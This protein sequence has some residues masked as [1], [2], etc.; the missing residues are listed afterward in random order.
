[1]ATFVR[2]ETAVRVQPAVAA[3]PTEGPWRL[4]S[5]D[6][7]RGLVMVV[8][9]LDHTR[10]YFS[11]AQF[12]PVDLSQTTPAYFL[13][14]WITHFCAPTFVFLAGTGAYLAGMRGKS[15]PQLSWF[16]L[17]RGLWLVVLEFTLVQWGWNFNFD[18]HFV[19]GAVIWAIGCSMMLLAA[20]VWLPTSAIGVFGVAVIAFHNLLDNVQPDDLGR[21]GWLWQ[22]L[23]SGGVFEPWQGFRFAAAYPLLPWMG[24]M[25]VGYAFGS[26]YRLDTSKRWK[27]LLG[28]G[29]MLTLAFIILRRSNLYGDPRPWEEQKNELFTLF[30][31]LNCW[32]YPPSLLFL[33]MTLGPAIFALGL[34]GFG[35]GP[36]GQPLVVFG[37][38]PLFFYLLHIPLIHL[39][40]AV[41][42]TMRFGGSPLWSDFWGIPPEQFRIESRFQLPV[43]Y[44]FWVMVVSILY[45]ACWWWA[46]VKQRRRYWWLSYL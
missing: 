33:L 6:L 46:R 30:S 35:L 5:V 17:S 37:R 15:K 40:A 28:L 45:P 21:L 39:L 29:A 4:D 27:L 41:C 12:D 3:R 43:V 24:V 44:L 10:A 32:K 20:L 25:A 16:L 26:I 7:L 9:A 22:I 14:R 13:T 19:G 18:R 11:N 42:E 31:F 34:F 2:P 38:V 1:M 8:M 23:H 36:I